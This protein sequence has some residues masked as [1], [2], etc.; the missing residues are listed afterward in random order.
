MG[1]ISRGRPSTWRP[2]TWRGCPGRCPYR[3]WRGWPRLVPRPCDDAPVRGLET[4]PVEVV[5][6]RGGRVLGEAVQVGVRTGAG[7]DGRVSFRDLATTL[8]FEG[9]RHHSGTALGIAMADQ[10][11]NEGDQ[12]IGQADSDLCAH[13]K[14]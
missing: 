11:V 6:R 12:V 14:K 9:S 8:P 13:T 4:P 1:R 3:R 5:H 10:V 2:R 7:E